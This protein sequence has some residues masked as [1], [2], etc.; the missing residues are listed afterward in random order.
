MAGETTT[1]N[2]GL[3]IA[4]F[5]QSNWQVPTN[6]NWNK[7]DLIFGGQLQVPALDVA[8]FT[9]G[10][11]AALLLPWFRSEQPA[12]AVP[13]SNYTLSYVPALIFGIY[14]NGLLL[15]PVL[16]YVVSGQVVTLNTATTTS[17]DTVWAVYLE[18]QTT[19][20]GQFPTPSATPAGLVVVPWSAVPVFDA[21]KGLQ[22]NIT[23]AGNVTGSLFI[24]G[25]AGPTVVVLT[26]VQNATGGWTFVWPSNMHNGG[27]VDADAGSTSTQMFAVNADGSANAVSPMMYS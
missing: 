7:L 2:I 16:D 6:F 22:F 1:P 23:L 4:A 18:T 13:G 27:V 17:T 8:N 21:S 26:I 9:I 11:V 10:N 14:V 25:A 5:N 24:N 19:W 20:N 12:G 3:Q 15:R